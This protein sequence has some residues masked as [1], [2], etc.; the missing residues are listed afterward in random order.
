MAMAMA[1]A[2][3]LAMALAMAMVDLPRMQGCLWGMDVAT[4]HG[5]PFAADAFLVN[6]PSTPRGRLRVRFPPVALGDRQ[7]RKV[8]TT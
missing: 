5:W 8:T 7:L 6:A 3:A 4:A 2:L 1:M